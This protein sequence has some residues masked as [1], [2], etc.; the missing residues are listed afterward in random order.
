MIAMRDPLDVQPTSD[1]TLMIRGVAQLAERCVWDAEVGGS[2]PPTP[3]RPTDDL[4]L[5]VY[6]LFLSD[7][8]DAQI[9]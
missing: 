7:L 2:S 4:N 9:G 3:T 8:G 1:Y 5:I 6:L